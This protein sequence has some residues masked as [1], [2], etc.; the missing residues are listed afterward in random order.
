MK[1]IVITGCSTGFGFQATQVFANRGDKV[2]ATMRNVDGKNSEAAANL[3]AASSNITVVDLDVLS[4]KSVAQASASI[5]E[6]GGAP[7]VVINNAGQMYVGLAEAFT[8]DE[9]TR[10]LDINVVGIHR[11]NRGL[12]PAMRKAGKGLIINLSSIAG[13]FGAPF[14]SVYHASKWAVEGYSLGMRRELATSGVDVVV[15]EPGPF[16]T[17]LFGQ[18]PS[19]KDD[20]GRADTYPEVVPQTFKGM[21]KAFEGMFMDPEVP[22]DPIDVVNTFV[23]LVDSQAGTRPFRSVVGVDL[24]VRARN[25]ADEAHE[26]PFLEAMGLTEFA[27]LKTE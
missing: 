21:G 23:T 11:V 17:E 24:G 2:F 15:V 20:E 13:R 10:Q 18:S 5:I 9:L 14:F 25:D 19:P 8:A 12:L 27:K 7:D 22:T 16:S 26:G 4:D 1:T 6:Q 3:R